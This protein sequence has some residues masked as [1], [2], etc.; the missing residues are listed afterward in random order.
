[1]SIDQLDISEYGPFESYLSKIRQPSYSYDRFVAMVVNLPRQVASHNLYKATFHSDMAVVCEAINL[2]SR[3]FPDEGSIRCLDLLKV[4]DPLIQV[5]SLNCLMLMEYLCEDIVISL[6][7]TEQDAEVRFTSIEYLAKL[8]S[9]KAIDT[10]QTIC[11]EDDTIDYE[12][13]PI[14]ALSAAAIS[15][16]NRS[17]LK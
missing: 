10:L 8:G 13:R 5:C 4:S 6:L 12:G 2:F 14:A 11:E 15:S 9:A 16:I 1:M 7:Q 17:K 3:L